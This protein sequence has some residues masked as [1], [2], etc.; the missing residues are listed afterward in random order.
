MIMRLTLI[1]I[2]RLAHAIILGPFVFHDKGFHCDFRTIV[3]DGGRH[4]LR[5]DA[6]SFR[7]TIL[8]AK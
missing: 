7:S 3:I 5:V 8:I 6:P 2:G 4:R 1:Y